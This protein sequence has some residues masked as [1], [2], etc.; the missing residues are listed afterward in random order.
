[1]LNMPLGPTLEIEGYGKISP[2]TLLLQAKGIW[3]AEFFV[4]YVSIGL[5]PEP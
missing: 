1:M 3:H 4:D 5:D 2:S